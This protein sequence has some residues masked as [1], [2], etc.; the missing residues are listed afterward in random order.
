VFGEQLPMTRSIEDFRNKKNLLHGSGPKYRMMSLDYQ[1][2]VILLLDGQFVRVATIFASKPSEYFES[3]L[4]YFV[5]EFEEM[6]GMFLTDFAGAVDA[7]E[8]ADGLFNKYL[9][10][11]M[12]RPIGLAESTHAKKLQK[13]VE[14]TDGELRMTNVIQTFLREKDYV[15]LRTVAS[16]YATATKE[17]ELNAIKAIMGLWLKGMLAPVDP[18]ESL[19]TALRFFS[20]E[21]AEILKV[22][23]SGTLNHDLIATEVKMSR[24][25]VDAKLQSFR[26]WKLINLRDQITEKGRILLERRTANNK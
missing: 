23:A 26:A 12:T 1:D 19:E 21:D 9:H 25:A 22:V 3:R 8:K 5:E 13:N 15:R 17:E 18:E 10:F 4:R 6:Y 7:F 20:Q 16:L 24:N 2:F 14:L 11:N